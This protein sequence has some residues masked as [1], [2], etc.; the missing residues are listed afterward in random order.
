MYKKKSF[1]KSAVFLSL[2]SML[3]VDAAIAQSSIALEEIVVTARKREESLQDTPV[4]VA[5]FSGDALEKRGLS[6]ISEVGNFTPNLTF[7]PGASLGSSTSASIF[8]RGVGQID[9]ALVVDPGVGLFVDG[10]YYS[11]S[12]GASLDAIEIE[13]LEV[14]RGPQGT[15]FGKNTIGGAINIKTKRP[16]EEFGGFIEGTLGNFDRTDVKAV[17][18]VPLSESARSKF[19]VSRNK[20]DGFVRSE[21]LPGSGLFDNDSVLGDKDSLFLQAQFDFDLSD[22]VSFNLDLDHT[23]KREEGAARVQ[24]GF[25]TLS[26]ATVVSFY[27]AVQA[28]AVAAALGVPV[29]DVTLGDNFIS[30][31]N[32]RSNSTGSFL[33][34]D[35][36]NGQVFG[37]SGSLLGGGFGSPSQSDLDVS[38]IGGTLN[39]DISDNLSFKAIAAYRETEAFFTRDT[40]GT[41]F[42]INDSYN[43]FTSD[44]ATFEVQLSGTS[45]NDRLNWLVGGFYSDES[46]E[47]VN[48]VPLAVFNIL[49]GGQIDIESKAIFGQATYSITDRLDVTAGIRYSEDDKTFLPVIAGLPQQLLAPSFVAPVGLPLVLDP[50]ATDLEFDDTS[51]SL[52]LSYRF[53]DDLLGYISYA[54]GYK[55]GGFTQ[56]LAPSVPTIPTFDEETN[57]VIEAGL[58]WTG[59]DGRVRVNASIFDS[60]YEDIQLTGVRDISPVIFN[61]AEAGISGLELEVEALLSENLLVQ[62]GY[63][64]LDAGYDAFDPATDLSVAAIFIDNDLPQSPENSLSLGIEYT[65]NS[66]FGE[67]IPRL[68][69]SYRSEIFLD[70]ANFNT[71]DSRLPSLEQ[72]SLTLV[73]ASLNIIPAND[74]WTITI[75]GQ[76]LT[77]ERY[78]VS[79]FSDLSPTGVG[80]ASGQPGRPREVSITAR[81]KF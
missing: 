64:Y 71:L 60:T 22:S 51:S 44:Q 19:T 5:A 46:G 21:G 6:N 52:S 58:K 37:Q 77:D 14:L 65:F 56:R 79:G 61:A 38:G 50:S 28:P 80:V 66:S 32:F 12:V 68:D 7:Q 69:V 23:R 75:A 16:S 78:L 30:P 9:Y 35:L 41:P 18:N 48:E 17:L 47:D 29:A 25:N 11:R 8:I 70:S 74:K 31:S 72:P 15:L 2:A 62:L 34:I 39:W 33:P 43:D 10:V 49:S 67:I 24:T 3:S 45:L 81:Y 36:G 76:N 4:S 57:E 13:S 53:T 40:D 26:P 54:E 59:L 1:A 55:S 73:N 63:G 42:P 27:N 20:R